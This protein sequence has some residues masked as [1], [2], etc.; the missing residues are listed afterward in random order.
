MPWTAQDAAAHNARVKGSKK[1]QK[2]WA[3]VANS[4]LAAELKKGQ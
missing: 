4:V 2:Q 1:L 3:E